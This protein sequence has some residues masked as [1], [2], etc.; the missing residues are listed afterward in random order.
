MRKVYL[1]QRLGFTLIEM[2]VTMA[3]LSLLAT[4]VLIYSHRTETL[5]NLIRDA[6]KLVF[7]LHQAQS[8]SMLTLEQSQT[9]GNTICGWG[10]HLNK[11]NMSQ[12]EYILFSD[13]CNSGV[14]NQYDSGEEVETIKL[15]RGVEIFKSNIS[16]VVFI[17]PNP[18]VRFTNFGPDEEN[19]DSAWICLRLVGQEENK[20][21]YR[22][23]IA[24]SGQIYKEFK[25]S[26]NVK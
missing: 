13:F 3:I 17:P 21:Y 14:Q 18:S 22:I 20:P 1:K 8:S 10:I 9:D 2:L 5:S 15:L 19:D 12:N 25:E 4:M 16:D 11:G 24:S 26:S 6:D 7:K 23:R